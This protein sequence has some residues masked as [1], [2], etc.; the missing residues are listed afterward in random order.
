MPKGERSCE[1]RG[2]F[3]T[4]PVKNAPLVITGS[5]MRWTAPWRNRRQSQSYGGG[6]RWPMLFRWRARFVRRLRS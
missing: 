6:K 4:S 5:E 1:A 3:A 2:H